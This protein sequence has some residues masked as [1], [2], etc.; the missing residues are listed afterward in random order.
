M[1]F[2]LNCYYKVSILVMI[3]VYMSCMLWVKFLSKPALVHYLLMFTYI[4]YLFLWP[5]GE[6]LT[7]FSVRFDE[8]FHVHVLDIVF[9]LSWDTLFYFGCLFNRCSR[10]I[11]RGY[12]LRWSFGGYNA[13]RFLLID[14]NFNLFKHSSW[15]L[16]RLG[17]LVVISF[18]LGVR[19]PC[20]RTLIAGSRIVPNMR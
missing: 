10:P 3:I 12:L 14:C 18:I 5:V 6:K 19:R 4:V 17:L 1:L 11:G 20:Y 15:S 8:I 7:S 9:N 16:A 2:D 13:T